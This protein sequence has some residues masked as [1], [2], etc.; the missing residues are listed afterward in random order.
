MAVIDSKYEILAQESLGDGQTL[1]DAVAPDG[2]ALRVM[3]FEFAS[4]EQEMR[5]ETYRQLL[6]KLE[7]QDLAALYD[8]VSRPGAHYVAWYVPSNGKAKAPPELEQLLTQYGYL[9]TNADIRA[10]RGKSV[11]YGLTF[12]KPLP[13][14]NPQSVLEEP[15]EPVRSYTLPRW[16]SIRWLL[17]WVLGMVLS[18]TG[19]GLWVLGFWL[20]ANDT[21]VT[22]PNLI[23]QDINAASRIFHALHLAVTVIATA[24]NEAPGSVISTDPSAGDT[25]RPG[26]TV[27]LSY[28]LPAGQ[29]ALTTVPQLR[30]EAMNS[31]VQ[32]TLEGAKLTLGTIAYVYTNVPPGIIISQTQTPNSQISANT[33]VGLLVSLG[34]K[35]E[36]T[37]IPNL[38]R[39]KLEDAQYFINLAGLPAPTL[40]RVA[41]SR[42]P[43]NT[44]LEQSIAANTLVS[45]RGSVLRLLVAGEDA[46]GLAT[47]GVP[48][49]VGLSLEEA[50]RVAPGYTLTAQEITTLNLPK[51]IVDQSPAPGTEGNAVTVILNVPPEPIPDPNAY[52]E[53]RKPSKRQVPYSFYIESGISNLD[54]EIIAKTIQG[55]FP[56]LRG[57]SV[58][59]GQALSG[60]WETTIPG[61]ITFTLLLNGNLYDEQQQNP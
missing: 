16:L 42:Y 60:S 26:R 58:S 14:I 31:T 41:T 56:I 45:Q 59:G 24:S 50:K 44:I 19:L 18:I 28:A 32:T 40:D 3:W 12:T 6:R 53:I 7:K 27:Q 61:P 4:L 13:D 43:A 17:A 1:F 22:I 20:G 52:A 54:A 29:V 33:A 10:D 15:E 34:P 5:F 46:S 11:L 47:E 57:K 48:S 8:I 49:L 21:V 55:E 37:F 39:L 35:G 36:Q 38:T 30:G 23:G 25:L 9:V 2:T 51:G